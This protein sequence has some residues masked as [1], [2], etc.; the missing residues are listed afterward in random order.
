MSVVLM[1]VLES[2]PTRYDRG[3]RLLTV[4]RVDYLRDWLA[5]HVRPGWRVLDL[6]SGTGALALRAASQGA[7]VVAVDVNPAMMDVGRRRATAA[8][9]AGRVTWREM[10]VAEM[11]SF[12]SRA[13]DAISAGLCFSELSPDERRYALRQ[14]QRTL[15]RDGRLLLLDEVRPVGS[16][17]R[18]VHNALRLPLV[19]LTWLLT[20]AST[21]PIPDPVELLAPV[22]FKVLESRTA[23]LG[24]LVAVVA[25]PL[26]EGQ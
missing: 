19:A 6:G 7:E 8:G 12:P 22:G 5:A 26:A 13:F 4:G 10:G 24:T 23:L 25:R 1:R 2:A 21:S 20:Q 11:D 18:L 9:L 14:A 3:I 17:H 16:L 15:E